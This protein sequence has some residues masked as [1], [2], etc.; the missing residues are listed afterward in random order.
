M[1]LAETNLFL[2]GCNKNGCLGLGGDFSTRKEVHNPTRLNMTNCYNI[3]WSQVACGAYHTIAVSSD[4][5]V[6]TWG[7]D[8]E[9]CSGHDEDKKIPAKKV[10]LRENCQGSMWFME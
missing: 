6:Y 7:R 3:V 2:C 1:A 8:R 10:F 4:G 5:E 9:G